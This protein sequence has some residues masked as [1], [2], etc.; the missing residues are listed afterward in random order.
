[1]LA[2]LTWVV[3]N[4]KAIAFAAVMAALVFAGWRLYEAGKTE[5]NQKHQIENLQANL[6]A[7]ERARK[8]TDAALLA[9]QRKAAAD[10]LAF[11]ELQKRKDA[12]HDYAESISDGLR[13]CLSGADVERLRDLWN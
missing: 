12:L 10:A 3:R 6:E 1:M 11:T 7:S 8:L 13:E 5:A 2:I 9:D 4:W